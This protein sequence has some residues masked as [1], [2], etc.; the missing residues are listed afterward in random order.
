MVAPPARKDWPAMSEGKKALKR[1]IKKDRVG[2]E[3]EEVNHKGDAKG[4]KASREE[5]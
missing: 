3:P 2:T 4:N 5:R 1:R